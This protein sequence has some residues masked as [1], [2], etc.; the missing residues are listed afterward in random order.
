MQNYDVKKE[1]RDLYSAGHD[2]FALV[3]VPRMSFLMADGHGNP[4]T[5]AD[6]RAVV[7][8]LY[9]TAYAVR[10]IVKSTEG[11]THTVGP[12]EGLW[13]ADDLS[14]FETRGYDQWKWTLMIVQ[15]E[16]VTSATVE[17]A[18]E[19]VARTKKLS[20]GHRVRFDDHTEG[21]CVQILHVGPYDEEGPTIKRMHEEFMPAQRLAPRGRHHEIY[22]S[23]ARRTDP[24]RLRTILRQP[25][26]PAQ[27]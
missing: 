5:S 18:R 3:D 27:N 24:R 19:R 25:V 10:A 15:P 21:R 4:N 16:W 12:L 23:D 1:R 9:T 6:Y 7:E 20:A 2:R 8:A 14:V 13:S 11:R 17:E 26:R 22:L